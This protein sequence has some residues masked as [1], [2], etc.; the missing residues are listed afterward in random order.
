MNLESVK[1]ELDKSHYAIHDK[2]CWVSGIDSGVSATLHRLIL[3]WTIW[4]IV[5]DASGLV[6]LTQLDPPGMFPCAARLH[7]RTPY[8]L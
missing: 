8:A 7:V 3:S 2:Q 5:N 1:S 4:G 6:T